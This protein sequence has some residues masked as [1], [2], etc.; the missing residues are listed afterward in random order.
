MKTHSN[1]AYC[2]QQAMHRAIIICKKL[3]KGSQTTSIVIGHASMIYLGRKQQ[4][5]RPGLC[6]V[7][8]ARSITS[9]LQAQQ[10]HAIVKYAP[11]LCR[12]TCSNKV[13]TK[14][15]RN[16]IKTKH[17][18]TNTPVYVS[19]MLGFTAKP[20]HYHT[21]HHTDKHMRLGQASSA[22]SS[23]PQ[24]QQLRHQKHTLIRLAQCPEPQQTLHRQLVAHHHTLK[25]QHHVPAHFS[26]Q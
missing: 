10:Q 22:N 3:G 13:A 7:A 18:S 20:N 17:T 5:N 12:H 19:T 2:K 15:A 11:E 24:Q 25:K 14:Y 16:P 26:T 1:T 21:T 6:C 8:Q 9:A 4:H 23:T